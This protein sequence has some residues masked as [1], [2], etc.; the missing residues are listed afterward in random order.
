MIQRLRGLFARYADRHL[1]YAAP[2]PKLPRVGGR[3]VGHVDRISVRENRLL[4]EG[5]STAR[6]LR[7]TWS[8][9]AAEQR[10]HMPRRDVAQSLGVAA[11]VGFLL[12]APLGAAPYELVLQTETG[13]LV[14]PVSAPAG[15]G[16]YL[17]RLRLKMRFARQLVQILPA[18]LR[19]RRSRDPALRAQIKTRLGLDTVVR[20]GRMEDRLFASAADLPDIPADLAITI[21]LPVYN[22]HDLLIEALARVEAHTDLPWYLIVI[23]DC[24]TDPAIRPFLREWAAPRAE[25]VTLLEN[26]QNL[27]FIGSVNKGLKQALIRGN[28]VVLLNSDALVPQAWA[29]RLLRP[30]LRWDRVASVTPMSND[31]EIFTLPEICRR[32]VLAPGEGDA[33]D[34]VAQQFHPEMVLPE[35]PTG[36]GF[37]MAVNIACLREIPALDDSFGRGYG[38]E[39][40]WCQKARERG[41]RHLGLAG[42]FVEHRGGE[43]F[44]SAE[45]RALVEKNNAIISGRY[46]FYDREVQEFIQADPLVTARVALAIA[47]LGARAEGPVPIYLAH[48]LGGGAENYLQRRIE[49]GLAA[50]R[51]AIICRVGGAERFQIE[52]RT[53]AGSVSGL[54]SNQ[55]YVKKLLEPVRSRKIVY[56]CGVG[57]PDPLTLPDFLL[58]LRRDGTQDRIEVLFHDFFAISPSYCLLD[59]D[60]FYRGPVTGARDDPA[61]IHRHRDGTEAPLHV[62]Q[63]SWGR[64]LSA[65]DQITVFSQD[66][67]AHVLAAYP[68]VAAALR[69]APHHLLADIPRL[70]DPAPGRS[71]IGV[72]GNIG[73]QKGAALLGDLGRRLQGVPDA[74]LVLVGNIDPAYPVPASVPIHGDY[75]REEIAS[76]VLRYGITCWLIPSIWPETFS[77]TT[78]EC[79]ATGLPVLA[80]DIGAQGEAVRQAENGHPIRFASDADLVQNIL[81]AIAQTEE[82]AHE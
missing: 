31:A 9:G 69:V 41:W 57:D 35:A 67:R 15:T 47:Y 29:Q 14:Q 74:A 38:E 43:S 61:H 2:G 40:D 16:L 6:A 36:V 30:I 13:D 1:S 23:E 39:V 51:S 80:F 27:G 8:G 71:V 19:W 68:D 59:Q 81:D 28:H 72:L 17:A 65:A 24:S 56:S 7:L 34:A 25:R 76:L 60:G 4:I 10:P 79:L 11:D 22:A 44:G 37:C 66:S 54:T 77:Y 45:K 50:G 52:L 20:A 21:V 64:L 48:T 49:D 26:A 78:H 12:E 46:P 70:P 62:W 82:T 3:P 18:A 42:L 53:P 63:D 58:D 33:I 75:R 5:W 55:N 32:A 73:Y